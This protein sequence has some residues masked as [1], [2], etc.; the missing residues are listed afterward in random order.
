LNYSNSWV[1]GLAMAPT[2]IFGGILMAAFPLLFWICAMMVLLLCSGFVYAI[3]VEKAVKTRN[4][5]AYVYAA[6]FFSQ[7]VI[8]ACILFFQGR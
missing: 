7:I 3:T 4:K 8:Y 6:L 2:Y 1:A 5:P